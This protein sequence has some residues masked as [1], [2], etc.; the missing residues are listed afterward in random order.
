MAP[1]PVRVLADEGLYYHSHEGRENPEE[2]QLVAIS[3]QGCK[4]TADVGT[5]QRI[6]NLDA[7]KSEAQVYKLSEA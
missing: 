4:Y 3:A 5:L 7:K 6:G 1:R 2:G